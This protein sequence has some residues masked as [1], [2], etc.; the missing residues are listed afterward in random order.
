VQDTPLPPDTSIELAINRSGKIVY[1][2]STNLSQ[3]RR[4]PAELVDWLYR[5]TSF[6]QGCVLLTGTGIV[7]PDDFNLQSGDEI[8]IAIEPVGTLVNPVQ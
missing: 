8:R 6:P 7:P 2:G 1:S 5:A 3:M 4:S